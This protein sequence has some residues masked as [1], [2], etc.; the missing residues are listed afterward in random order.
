[1]PKRFL[2]TGFL[3]QK[4]IRKLKPEHKIFLIYIM[5]ECDNAGIIELDMEDAEFW[6]GK[7][8][9]NPIDFLPE[10]YLI[11]VNDSG[12]YFQPK[13]IEWQY[14]NFPVSRVHQQKQAKEILIKH[15]MFDIETQSITLP[16]FYPTVTQTLP[17]GQVIGN[18]NAI[19]DANVIVYPFENENFI[20]AW[21]DWKDYKK[22]QHKFTYKGDM[23]EQAALK[24]L[25][26]MCNGSMD[27]ALEI[28]FHSIAQ[29]YKG[30]YEPDNRDKKPKNIIEGFSESYQETLKL[31]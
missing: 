14:P 22:Q 11:P 19:V 29:G 30:L 1:M 8:I 12:K 5:L 27:Y 24:K 4:W 13:F 15:G 26:D 9:G 25:G 6:I 18:A 23:S 20:N 21:N 3:Q 17:D 28:I 2:D 10:G 16:N 7:K 31:L